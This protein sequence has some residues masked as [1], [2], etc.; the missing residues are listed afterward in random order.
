MIGL[1]QRTLNAAESSKIEHC[2]KFN[3]ADAD[4]ASSVWNLEPILSHPTISEDVRA[5]A[6]LTILPADKGEATVDLDRDAYIQKVE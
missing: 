6:P 1:S 5:M 2:I 3:T 4:T